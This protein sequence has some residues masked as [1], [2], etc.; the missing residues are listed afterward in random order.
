MKYLEETKDNYVIVLVIVP[1]PEQINKIPAS[2]FEIIIYII[3]LTDYIRAPEISSRSFLALY[4]FLRD[5]RD[6]S[7][8]PAGLPTGSTTVPYGVCT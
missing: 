8:W 2:I 4:L 6:E 7:T 3:I 1:F 5:C